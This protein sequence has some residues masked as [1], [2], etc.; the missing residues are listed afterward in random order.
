VRVGLPRLC[1]CKKRVKCDC[2]WDSSMEV[3][4]FYGQITEKL[5]EVFKITTHARMQTLI[6]Q[7]TA[8]AILPSR[9]ESFLPPR[10]LRN[11]LS[12]TIEVEMPVGLLLTISKHCEN[13]QCLSLSGEI[14]VSQDWLKNEILSFKTLKFLSIDVGERPEA[15]NLRLTS[16][17]VPLLE[18]FQYRS[19]LFD[20]DSLDDIF[21]PDIRKIT[22]LSLHPPH[23]PVVQGVRLLG[24]KFWDFFSNLKTGYFFLT[25]C[26]IVAPPPPGHPF[27]TLIFSPAEWQGHMGH[28]SIFNFKNVV[29]LCPSIKTVRLA[30]TWGRLVYRTQYE[31]QRYPFWPALF[32]QFQDW[33]DTQRVDIF[34]GDG[35]RYHPL[36]RSVFRENEEIVRNGGEALEKQETGRCGWARHD[37]VILLDP[38]IGGDGLMRLC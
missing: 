3:D 27:S 31:G 17:R 18:T 6:I 5:S 29:T 19:I 24:E 11:L 7:S 10:H 28:K 14:I 33:Y 1:G 22:T 23:S 34:D 38:C 8:T 16:W 36:F 21:S 30:T 25:T 2:E 20:P 35:T 15:L 4:L 32:T 12:L 13:L 9:V 37:C 26:G